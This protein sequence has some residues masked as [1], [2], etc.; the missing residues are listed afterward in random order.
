MR[1][2]TALAQRGV[3]GGQQKDADRKLGVLQGLLS[4]MRKAYD[5]RAAFIDP[6]TSA[7][8]VPYFYTT[9]VKGRIRYGD[10]DPLA[11]LRKAR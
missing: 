5:D 6:W 10:E 7:P 3:G 2:A 8:L 11:G 9:V 1:V 4:S